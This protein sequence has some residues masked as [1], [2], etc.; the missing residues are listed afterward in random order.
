[1]AQFLS[2]NCFIA[3]SFAAGWH[4]NSSSEVMS[5]SFS[6]QFPASS[7]KPMSRRAARVIW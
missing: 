1:M 7:L 3:S 4:R 5:H 2:V 6:V